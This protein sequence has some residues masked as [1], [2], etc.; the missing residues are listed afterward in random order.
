[1]PLLHIGGSLFSFESLLRSLSHTLT[2]DP[3][4]FFIRDGMK[5]E[6]AVKSSRRAPSK[7][8]LIYKKYKK[9]VYEERITKNIYSVMRVHNLYI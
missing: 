6:E 9:S 8:K 2:D 1:M 7:K 5:V 4:C 3:L